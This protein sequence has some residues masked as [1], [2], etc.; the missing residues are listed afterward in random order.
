ML[1]PGMHR[2]G[3]DPCRHPLHHPFCRGDDFRLAFARIGSLRSLIPFFVKFL[4]LTATCTKATLDA[5]SKRLS[6]DDDMAIIGESPLRHNIS[7]CVKKMPTDDDFLSRLAKD[8]I[9]EGTEYGKTVVFFNRLVDCSSLY[10]TMRKIMGTHFTFPPGS[11]N[12]HG[13]RL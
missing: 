3:K 6:M 10:S 4:A 11:P 8:V 5:V 13:F 12:L 7:Y 1:K 9:S 2:L